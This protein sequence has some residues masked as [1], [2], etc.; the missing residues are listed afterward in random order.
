MTK[1]LKI[2]LSVLLMAVLGVVGYFAWQARY[3]LLA[4]NYGVANS[5]GSTGEMAGASGMA[6]GR[7]TGL[8]AKDM[9]LGYARSEEPRSAPQP[10]P[11][12]GGGADESVERLVIQTAQVSI[13]VKDVRAAAKAV[14]DFAIAAGGFVVESNLYKNDIAPRGTVVVRVP[15]AKFTSG[16]LEMKALGE[17]QSE[18]TN[19]TDVTE[20]YVDLNAR[21][22]NLQATEKQFLAILT[23]AEKITD[24]LAVQQELSRVR[25]E[26]ESFQGRIKYLKQSADLSSITVNLTTDPTFQ[27]VVEPERPVWKPL[28]TLKD[29]ARSLVEAGKIIG[30]LLIWVVV[31]IPVWLV[32]ALVLWLVYR[33][34]FKR[35]ATP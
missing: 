34:L 24:I 18:N 10:T 25:G 28:A 22:R 35:R 11:P 17:V 13:L 33:F 5:S 27:P 21:L 3:Q 14:A 29:A 32:V 31:F 15:A 6:Y 2:F 7:A 9:A 30:T 20:E 16:L 23:K 19:G 4:G 12:G 8:V 1:P 26:I